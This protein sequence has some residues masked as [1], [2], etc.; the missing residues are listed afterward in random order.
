[1]VP[2]FASFSVMPTR[3]GRL[4]T[5]QTTITFETATA[6]AFS[7]IPPGITCGAPIRLG[8]FIGFGRE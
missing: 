8:S 7:M 4:Q 2:P 6:D 1:M 5:G 3:V